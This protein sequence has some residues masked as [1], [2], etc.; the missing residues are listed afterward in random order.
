MWRVPH[1]TVCIIS[2]CQKRCVLRV[3][4]GPLARRIVYLW[5]YTIL[6][7]VCPPTVFLERCFRH[8]LLFLS[9]WRTVKRDC[10]GDNDAADV[11]W[12]S[13]M[14]GFSFTLVMLFPRV[15]CYHT[16]F[17]A[18]LGKEIRMNSQPLSA[19]IRTTYWEC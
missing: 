5:I 3:M 1:C 18:C 7:V 4:C 19:N 16:M 12:V 14:Q 11:T 17:S 8:I 6:K 15:I 10:S 2:L 13:R 9:F